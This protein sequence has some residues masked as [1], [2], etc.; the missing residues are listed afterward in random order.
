MAE[1][2]AK[3]R[4]PTESSEIQNHALW[5]ILGVLL[6]AILVPRLLALDQF[7]TPDERK[8]LARSGNFYQALS[9]GDF[10]ST[11]QR[12]HPGV[13]VM[14]AGTAGFLWKYPA[15][16]DEAPGQFGWKY[17]EIEPFLHQQGYDPLELLETG[18]LFVV[19]GITIVLGVSFLL[20]VR[21]LG[22]WPAAIG[23][24]LIAFDPFH[25]GLSRLLHLDALVSSLMLLSLLA[26]FTYLYRGRH[27][28]DL[29]LSAV[30]AGL[31]WLTKSPAFFLAPFVG[32]VMLVEMWRDWRSG[33]YAA[34]AAF[35]RAVVPLIGWAAVGWLVFVVTWPAMW[36][37][38]ISSL[39]QIFNTAEAYATEGHLNPTYFAGTVTEG[40]PG[41]L[42]YP[43]NYVW[44]AT[45]AALLGLVLAGVALVL[46]RPPLET[47]ASR[48]TTVGFF[49]FALL[50]TAFMSLGAKKFDR[51]LLPI[52]APLDLIAGVGWTAVVLFLVNRRSLL[53]RAAPLIAV[54]VIALQLFGTVRTFP[55]YLSYYN[56]LVGGAARAPD[57][58]LIGWGEGLD[59]AARYLNAKPDAEQLSVSAWYGDGPFSYYFA[60]EQRPIRFNS[61]ITNIIRWLTTDYVVLYANQWQRRLP[62]EELLNYFAEQT[63]EKV[64]TIDGLEYVRIYN[65]RDAPPPD[66][67]AVGRPRFTDWGGAIRLIAYKMPRTPLQPREDFQTTFYLQNVGPINTNLN[68]LVRIFGAAGQEVLR[69]E[70][71]PWG[72]PTSTWKHRQVWPDGHIFA[73]PPDTEPGYYRVQVEFYDPETLDKL[74][75]VDART[76]EPIGTAFTVDYLT[77]AGIDTEPNHPLHPAATLGENVRLL[78]YD[79]WGNGDQMPTAVR[80]GEE[81]RARLFWEVKKSLETDYTAFVHLVGPDNQLVA[82]HD[83]E[84]LGGFFPT[85]YWQPGQV[86]R[87]ELYTLRLPD[88]AAPGT[89]TLYAGMYDLESGQRLPV[90]RDGEPTGD[91]VM[92][93]TLNVE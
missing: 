60:G 61:N 28:T 34:T 18:R 48:R 40:D 52:Y 22:F 78:G 47:P 4:P 45:P 84:P 86:V 75:A 64:V 25:V 35:R 62:T 36:V 67:L 59:Q 53:Q 42:F 54:L 92:L 19:V 56:P 57:V 66:Y 31:A 71:W 80:S 20:A 93:T 49:L 81:L 88:D 46:R 15:Y 27:R 5:L 43:I 37:D 70:G 91:A 87:D 41:W 7:V 9:Q 16:A 50:F 32:L 55:Y 74:P 39:Y 12:E 83:Q 21:L 17:E 58:M 29:V 63:P 44:R 51:Y 79:V 82:Q 33:Q 65:V 85:S 72:A 8:W 14:W 11:F 90:R 69:D 1:N 3:I 68:V 24:V 2:A 13:T 6:L 89:Y 26:F 73:F 76:G 23:F 30:A 77:V 38:P 10:A